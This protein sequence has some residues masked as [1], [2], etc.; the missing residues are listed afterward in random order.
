MPRVGIF[1]IGPLR[2]ELR[3]DEADMVFGNFR[4]PLWSDNLVLKSQN[5]LQTQRDWHALVQRT[6]SITQQV[7]DMRPRHGADTG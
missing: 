2:A 5:G 3:V 4:L 6:R 7:S 1:K